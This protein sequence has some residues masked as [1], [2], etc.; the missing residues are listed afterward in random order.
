LELQEYFTIIVFGYEMN[1]LYYRRELVAVELGYYPSPE[2]IAEAIRTHKSQYARV[3]K[4]YRL[5][6]DK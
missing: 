4:R 1:E 2:D 5:V 3:E 6:E